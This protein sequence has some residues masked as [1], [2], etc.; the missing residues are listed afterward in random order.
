MPWHTFPLP[1]IHGSISSAKRD[2]CLQNIDKSLA[3]ARTPSAWTLTPSLPLATTEKGEP[4]GQEK[5]KETRTHS[6]DEIKSPCVLD[7]TAEI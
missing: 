1:H 4:K 5:E 7:G 6:D 3:E 2:S